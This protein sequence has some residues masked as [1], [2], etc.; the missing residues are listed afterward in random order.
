MKAKQSKAHPWRQSGE[1]FR[2]AIEAADRLRF[3]GKKPCR[4]YYVADNL[5]CTCGP[6]GPCH[7]RPPK[8]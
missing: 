2:S 6:F 3:G 8:I 1:K 5:P 4:R 7:M